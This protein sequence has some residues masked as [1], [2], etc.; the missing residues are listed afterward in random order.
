M[1]DT[2]QY[3]RGKFILQI[4]FGNEFFACEF[5]ML[6]ARKGMVIIIT[7]QVQLKIAI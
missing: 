6:K 2:S 5:T 4:D 3:I 1:D 7:K